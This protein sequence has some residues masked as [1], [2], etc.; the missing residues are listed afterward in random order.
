M[1]AWIVC[2]QGKLTIYSTITLA[3]KL[4]GIWGTFSKDTKNIYDPYYRTESQKE[5]IINVSN[6]KIQYKKAF[7]WLTILVLRK[8]N[9]CINIIAFFIEV[10]KWLS[11]FS[12]KNIT[13]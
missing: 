8:K 7:P 6:K 12:I 9:K 10:D 11:I 2:M 13:A 5:V 4:L 1:D 3:L